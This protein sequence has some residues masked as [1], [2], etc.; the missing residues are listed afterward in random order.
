MRTPE[1]VKAIVRGE[2]VRQHD[3]PSRAG[4]HVVALSVPSPSDARSFLAGAELDVDVIAAQI[5]DRFM[6]AFIRARKGLGGQ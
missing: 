2:Y 5:H 4:V 6:S 1:Q 3:K